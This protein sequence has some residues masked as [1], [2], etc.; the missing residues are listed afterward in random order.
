MLVNWRTA[1]SW[2]ATTGR[3]AVTE[4]MA[5][6]LR[7]QVM[8]RVLPILLGANDFF[9]DPEANRG[10]LSRQRIDYLVIVDR[11][12]RIGTHSGREPKEGDAEAVASLPGVEPVVRD[13]WVT[14]F[15]VGAEAASRAREHPGRCP[16]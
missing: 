6:F 11:R 9:D 4:G 10:F 16:L 8:E 14:I 13:R 2:E 3:P 15:A 7:P 12:V 1:G 5:P